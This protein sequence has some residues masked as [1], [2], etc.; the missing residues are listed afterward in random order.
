MIHRLIIMVFALTIPFHGVS[1]AWF[2]KTHIAVGEAAG[3][4]AYYDLAAP[5]IAK[6]RAKDEG[7]NHYFDNKPDDV[8]TVDFIKRQLFEK[9][10]DEGHL[11]AAIIESLRQYID[12][13]GSGKFADY[14]MV[15]VGH[16]VGDLVMPLH[17]I[18]QNSWGFAYHLDVDGTVEKD[19]DYKKIKIENYTLH[20]EDEVM[21]KIADLANGSLRMANKMQTDKKVLTEEETYTQLSKGA[22]LFKAILDY[23][24][25]EVTN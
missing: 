5:D 25:R 22:S 1:Y 8:V 6:I 12:K 10:N 7:I 9:D 4:N 3:F 2:D 16:Y 14:H 17:N 15:Y 19:V 20:N 13:K 21:A 24:D 18:H 11:Y 23:A